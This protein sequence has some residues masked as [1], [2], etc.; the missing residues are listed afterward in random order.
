MQGEPRFLLEALWTSVDPAL[1]HHLVAVS[2]DLEFDKSVTRSE[3]LVLIPEN[4]ERALS[5]ASEPY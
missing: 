2:L 5:G 3:V 4:M 1:R